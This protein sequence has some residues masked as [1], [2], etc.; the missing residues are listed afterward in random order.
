[1]KVGFTCRLR[2]TGN[3]GT[4]EAQ[5]DGIME[6]LCG[7]GITDPWIGATMSTGEVDVS[8]QVEAASMD[9]AFVQAMATIRSAIHAAGGGTPDWPRFE[10]IELEEVDIPACV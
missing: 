7:L 8:L 10:R 3:R 5:L 2:A 4:L 1:M 9:E 6:E